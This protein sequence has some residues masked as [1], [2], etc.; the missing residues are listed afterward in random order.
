[1]FIVLGRR[2]ALPRSL[3]EQTVSGVSL[4]G[5]P[6]LLSPP[7]PWLVRVGC[8][9][10]GSGTR[11][12]FHSEVQLKIDL[13]STLYLKGSVF[14]GR[15]YSCSRL[16]LKCPPP[17]TDPALGKGGSL[18]LLPL[19]VSVCKEVVREKLSYVG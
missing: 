18:V 5:I 12:V 4:M 19:T 7:N 15:H 6:P 14:K 3:P 17:S 9:A 8:A 2:G 11:L 16:S 13:N 10:S 1:M